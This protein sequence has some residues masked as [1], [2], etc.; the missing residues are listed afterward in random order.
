[1]EA[2]NVE[3]ASP[4]TP[5]G[6]DSTPLENQVAA[7]ISS[8]DNQ[9][10]TSLTAGEV[11]L[12]T[13]GLIG[14]D[15][16]EPIPGLHTEQNGGTEVQSQEDNDDPTIIVP[17][18]DPT[19][20]EEVVVTAQ[21]SEANQVAAS[22][23]HLQIQL[24]TGQGQTIPIVIPATMAS[25]AQ[26][27]IPIPIN[28]A[29]LAGLNLGGLGSGI[30]L[31]LIA[32]PQTPKSNGE[33]SINEE[34]EDGEAPSTPV[35]GIPI[36]I[37]MATLQ[38]LLGMNPQLRVGAGS[39]QTLTL[40]GQI[41]FIF[42]PPNTRQTTKRS[43]CV[44]PNCTEIQKS[45]ERPKRRTH[46]CHYTGCGKVYGKT[47]HLK[48]HLRTHTGE[49]PYVCNWPLCDRKFT[50]SDEL[51]RHLKTHTGE[52]NFLCK[53]CDKR[54]MRS[55]HL[56]KHMKIHGK[57]RASPRKVGEELISGAPETVQLLSTNEIE[58]QMSAPEVIE[59]ITTVQITTPPEQIIEEMAMDTTPTQVLENPGNVMEADQMAQAMEENQP[60]E[61]VQGILNELE[62]RAEVVE[63]VLQ[64]AQ[65]VQ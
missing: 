34:S 31:T 14:G 63:V 64:T 4:N 27:G 59:Q 65:A 53:Q 41:P 42:T 15:T 62:S 12:Q 32:Q 23:S 52:K 54:F 2:S 11:V 22:P 8:S 38:A 20:S 28:L 57:E 43:N 18:N 5:Q 61:E 47:S 17:S 21:S 33:G 30:P 25:T 51:H 29:T 60:N 16:E 1:M 46:I 50:R 55:D 40:N 9:Q 10:A 26:N 37:N 6:G 58:V 19:I 7:A 36:P 48:A 13:L 45:G 56:S 49:K 35:Q 3:K 44:C 24:N 39:P